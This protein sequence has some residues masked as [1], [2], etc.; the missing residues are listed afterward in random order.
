MNRLKILLFV[1]L[2]IL[3]LWGIRAGLTNE[4]DPYWTELDTLLTKDYFTL[5]MAADSLNLLLTELQQ[6]TAIGKEGYNRIKTPFMPTMNYAKFKACLDEVLEQK[7]VVFASVSGVG[8]TT[9]TSRISSFIATKP[10]NILEIN[11]APNFDIILHHQYIGEWKNG[12]FQPGKLIQ[13]F[14]RCEA[15][16]TEKFVVLFDDL[17]KINPESFWGADFWKQFDDRDHKI[18]LEG[19]T[20]RIPNNFYMISVVHASASEKKELNNEHFR[21]IGKLDYLEIFPE[22]M[23]LYWRGKLAST[24]E[25]LAKGDLKQSE[26]KQLERDLASLED[27][28]HL[29][30]L[31][32]SFKKT[33]EIIEEKYSKNHRLGQWSSLRKLYHK[34][35]YAEFLQ[36][37]INHVNG[38]QPKEEFRKKDLDGLAYSL[39]NE[40]AIKGSNFFNQQLIVLEEK[41]Y[42]T[43]FFVGLSFLL[44]SGLVSFVVL[45]RREKIISSYMERLGRLIDDYENR[46]KNYDEIVDEFNQ[47]KSEVDGL[48][49]AKKINYTE[50]SF[51]YSFFENRVRQI[52]FSRE[53][54]SHFQELI[55]TFLE[56][57]HLSDNEYERLNRFLQK[58]RHKLSLQDYNSFKEEIERL[59]DKY[60]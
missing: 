48:T 28:T 27:T 41:G 36:V 20:L 35:E 55:D 40:G 7:Y 49:L 6:D 43:E 46:S 19:I 12:V 51:F 30:Q 15:N 56:D 3:F 38:F 57:E 50:A 26:K 39:K 21:R 11:C 32:Y 59:H 58:I 29:K 37:F 53:A 2:G 47:I 24:K 34:E 60:K 8:T 17:D 4:Q 52:E 10:E 14:K 42:L 23:I 1:L 33:N 22:E 54:N 13:F 25:K 31:A 44:I 45:K 18:E 16:P 9:I 5:E